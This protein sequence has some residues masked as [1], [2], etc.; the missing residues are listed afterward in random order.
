[1]AGTKTDGVRSIS[2]GRRGEGESVVFDGALDGDGHRGKLLVGKINRR[3]GE[4]R[5]FL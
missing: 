4:A 5:Q 1:M 3:H 2:D